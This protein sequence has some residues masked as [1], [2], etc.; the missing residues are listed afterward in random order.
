M[1]AFQE[2]LGVPPQETKNTPKPELKKGA[3]HSGIRGLVEKFYRIEDSGSL[4]SARL[5]LENLKERQKTN[6]WSFV[7]N[8]GERINLEGLSKNPSFEEIRAALIKA[9]KPDLASQAAYM[10]ERI[11]F[12]GLDVTKIA[13]ALGFA[14]VDE[15]ND[16]NQGEKKRTNYTVNIKGERVTITGVPLH[17]TAQDIRDGLMRIGRSDLAAQVGSV[18]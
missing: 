11:T 18:G 3:N 14:K 6:G 8:N 13:K 5:K 16:Q 10:E 17:P 4:R 1:N 2:S 7:S 15:R 9:G 12:L